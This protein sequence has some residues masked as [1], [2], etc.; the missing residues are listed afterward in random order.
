MPFSHGKDGGGC[1]FVCFL[2]RRMFSHHP[3]GEGLAPPAVSWEWPWFAVGAHS[4]RPSSVD[5]DARRARRL[6]A[7]RLT[8]FRPAGRP[9]LPAAA[10]EAN[11]RRGRL[12]SLSGQGPSGSS[13]FPPDPR[14]RGLSLYSSAK[15]PARKIRFRTSFLPGHWALVRC[16]ISVGTVSP[17]RLVPTSRGRGCKSGFV[18]RKPSGKHRGMFSAY[19]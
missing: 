6:G 14:L 1:V 11:R 12:T 9:P 19:P 4:V 13:S 15:V 3:V 18:E 10:K 17:P 8:G 16:K 7:P 2:R 5:H